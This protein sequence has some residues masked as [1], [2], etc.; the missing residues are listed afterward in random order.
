MTFYAA[1]SADP[2]FTT[3]ELLQFHWHIFNG[4][5][6][7]GQCQVIRHKVRVEQRV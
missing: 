4:G 1:G 2:D 7:G 5:L 3:L 6:V